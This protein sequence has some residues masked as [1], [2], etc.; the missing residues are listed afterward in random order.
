LAVDII[1]TNHNVLERDTNE[2]NSSLYYQAFKNVFMKYKDALLL[3]DNPEEHTTI[4]QNIYDSL[5]TADSTVYDR[6]CDVS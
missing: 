4:P 3:Y 6:P 2:G 1:G 5:L